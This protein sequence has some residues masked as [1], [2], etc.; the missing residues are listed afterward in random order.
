MALPDAGSPSTVSVFEFDPE[1]YV[2]SPLVTFPI[3]STTS[4]GSGEQPVWAP[5]RQHALLFDDSGRMVGVLDVATR[6]V[7]P[8]RLD[9]AAN[10]ADQTTWSPAGD[11]FAWLLPAREGTIIVITDVLG[12]QVAEIALPAALELNLGQP[13]WSPDGSTILMLGG[14]LPCEPGPQRH[15]RASGRSTDP[16]AARRIGRQRHSS[17]MVARRFRLRLPD[18]RRASRRSTWPTVVKAW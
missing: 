5:D 12:R 18:C 11:R 10:G 1:T 16:S 2:Q 14:C 4:F 13:R 7:T 8:L 15:R 17:R 9:D 3:T 6:V